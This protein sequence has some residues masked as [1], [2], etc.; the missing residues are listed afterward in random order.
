MFI[1]ASHSLA[2]FMFFTSVCLLHFNGYFQFQLS[3]YLICPVI[4]PPPHFLHP[5]IHLLLPH[6]CKLIFHHW[7]SG[8]RAAWRWQRLDIK[9]ET[10]HTTISSTFD[11]ESFSRWILKIHIR[12]EM[13]ENTT[14]D[15][16][17]SGRTG[18][19]LYVQNCLLNCVYC[20]NVHHWG[21][22]NC[23]KR[24]R[25]YQELNNAF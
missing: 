12:H 16:G 21:D 5:F 18:R 22:K 24:R 17:T 15:G 14:G 25:A 11:K 3:P 6:S 2:L 19:I 1:Q 20:S 13:F 4:L 23:R 9:H 8:D 10:T 7:M